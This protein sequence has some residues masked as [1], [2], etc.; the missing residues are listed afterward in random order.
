MEGDMLR[1]WPKSF[2]RH[3]S[4]TFYFKWEFQWYDEDTHA[5]PPSPPL[6][7]PVLCCPHPEE[8]H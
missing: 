1:A 6:S 4:M 5:V 3:S 8:R 7:S 2:N